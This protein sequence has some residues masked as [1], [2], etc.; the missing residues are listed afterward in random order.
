MHVVR[1]ARLL[2]M[3]TSTL[4]QGDTAVITATDT[5]LMRGTRVRIIDATDRHVVIYACHG[6][7]GALE[8]TRLAPLGSQAAAL[9]LADRKR[10]AA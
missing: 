6:M 10:R 3:I 5:A 8:R 9:A 1:R 4:R 7:T 2:A